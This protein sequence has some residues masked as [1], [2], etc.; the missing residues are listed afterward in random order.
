MQ[1]AIIPTDIAKNKRDLHEFLDRIGIKLPPIKSPGVTM[2]YMRK[3]YSG[4]YWCPKY[5]EL[6]VRTCYR[7]PCKERVFT[8]VV[9][10]LTSTNAAPI[11]FSD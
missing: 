11:G 4:E 10:H 5:K 3:T 1:N 6:K 8:E 9:M 7:P 2:D